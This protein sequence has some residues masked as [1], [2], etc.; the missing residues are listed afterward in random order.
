[1]TSCHD[2]SNISGIVSYVF[3]YNWFS[4]WQN[5]HLFYLCLLKRKIIVRVIHWQFLLEPFCDISYMFI[6]LPNTVIP[7]ALQVVPI[8][9]ENMSLFCAL[10]KTR[11]PNVF[12]IPY[13][14]KSELTV[15]PLFKH[16]WQTVCIF[17]RA[18]A[19]YF[20]KLGMI[21]CYNPYYVWWISV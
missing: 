2:H 19:L 16:V 3:I 11:K 1:M 5:G 8:I 13:R 9:H 12:W 4:Q 7:N 21:N 18:C 20:S 17:I 10:P 15:M 14:D 6:R